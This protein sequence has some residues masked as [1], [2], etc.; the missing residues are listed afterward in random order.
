MRAGQ[1]WLAL[2]CLLAGVMPSSV[3][4]IINTVPRQL[5]GAGLPQA[6][7]HG[8]LWLTPVS[9]ATASYSA[10]LVVLLLTVIGALA[11]WGLHRGAVRRVRR[12]DPWDCGFAPPT[13]RM[14]YTATAFAQPIRRVFGL[15]FHIE[16]SVAPREDGAVRH[17][18]AIAD[19]AWGLFYL[20]VARLVESAARRVVQLQ[21]GNVRTYLGWTLATLLVLLWIIS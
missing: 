14:Q 1:A 15:L 12:C 10:P 5:F 13:P 6:T 4:D 16:E 21:S 19:R 18:L 7:A 8:W 3:I 2:L 20:P 9:S 11:A 17:Q